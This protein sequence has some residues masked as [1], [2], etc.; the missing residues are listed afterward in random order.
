[1][2]KRWGRW[3]VFSNSYLWRNSEV[4]G[5]YIGSD[6]CPWQNSE[7]GGMCMHSVSFLWQHSGITAHKHTHACPWTCM[8]THTHACTPPHPHPPTHTHTDFSQLLIICVPYK[9]HKNLCLVAS[10]LVLK[11]TLRVT[12][13]LYTSCKYSVKVIHGNR[14]GTSLQVC[15]EH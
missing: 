11:L 3:D 4:G 10:F 1:M 5:T 7:V 9:A 2:T 8:H 13:V 15:V 14:H 12:D 6:N